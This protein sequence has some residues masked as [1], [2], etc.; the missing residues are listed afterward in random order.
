M[1]NWEYSLVVNT[2]NETYQA[3]VLTCPAEK[4]LTLCR[5]WVLTNPAAPPPLKWH[6]NIYPPF[7][8]GSVQF[9]LFTLLF[10]ISVLICSLWGGQWW[11]IIGFC[12]CLLSAIVYSLRLNVSDQ[13]RADTVPARGRGTAQYTLC[14]EGGLP[15]VLCTWMIDTSQTLPLALIGCIEPGAV[16]SSKSNYSY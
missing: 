1:R 15:A 14:E 9:F 16:D 11:G 8:S 3:G 4:Q 12:C 5:S 10:L 2:Q 6:L 13:V 7:F